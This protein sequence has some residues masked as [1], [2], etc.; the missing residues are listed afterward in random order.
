MLYNV[1]PVTPDSAH[2]CTWSLVGGKGRGEESRA[3]PRVTLFLYSRCGDG[4]VKAIG[5]GGRVHMGTP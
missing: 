5:R 4:A 3:S 1:Q 2:Y